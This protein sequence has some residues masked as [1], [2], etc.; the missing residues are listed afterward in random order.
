MKKLGL[1]IVGNDAVCKKFTCVKREHDVNA[2]A[3]IVVKEL[4]NVTE[5]R[6]VQFWNADATILVTGYVTP[7]ASVIVLGI[8]IAPVALPLTETIASVIFVV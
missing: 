4:G 7:L 1:M 6:P 5:V 2:F 8:I 3:P